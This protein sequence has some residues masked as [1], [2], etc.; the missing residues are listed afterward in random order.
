MSNE[1][2]IFNNEEFGE[3]R[4]IVIDD[5][6]YFMATDVASALGYAK[7]NNA[8][9]AHCKATL[10]QG[11]PISGKIQECN[12][13]AEGDV[14]RL[15][16]KSKLPAAEKFEKWVMEEVLPQIR[17]TGTYSV[18]TV[19][20]E[21]RE[22][23]IS[24]GLIAATE[25]IEEQKL[26]I[27]EQQARIEEMQ[28]KEDFYHQ[29]EA[30]EDTILVRDLAKLVNQALQNCG[31]KTKKKVSEKTMFEYLRENGYLIKTKGSSYNTP[32]QRSV[33]LGVMQIKTSII[34]TDNHSRKT[35]TAKITGKGCIYFITDILK[36]Y[37]ID[38]VQAKQEAA[39]VI[40]QTK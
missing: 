3:I 12:F 32:T 33:D 10:K 1:L 34:Q 7:P 6:P 15:I 39:N 30:S 36:H 24:R 13:I 9:T 23:L 38:T 31:I 17:Q 5:K 20:K 2:A 28:P 19:S 26:V 14:Y 25:V 11:I 4:T 37:Q 18:A 40:A 22:E 21:S 35:F 16:V 8:V 27:E 29:I